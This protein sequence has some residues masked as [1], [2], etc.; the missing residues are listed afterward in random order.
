MSRKKKDIQKKPANS[1]RDSSSAKQE[2]RE[3][4]KDNLW[5]DK[6]FFEKFNLKSHTYLGE[7]LLQMKVVTAEQLAEAL[8]H[9]PSQH[10]R[11]GEY[12]ISKGLA[13]DE[14]IQAALARQAGIVFH[15][16]L[17]IKLSNE[18]IKRLSI[19]FIK[20]NLIVPVNEHDHTLEVAMYDPFLLQPLDD[21]RI[22]FSDYKIQTVISTKK[23]IEG[24]I[25]HYF[26]KSSTGAESML[27]GLDSADMQLLSTKVEETR[28]LMEQD[29]DSPIIQLVD[30]M[31][32][33]AVTERAS[34]IHIEPF[35]KELM[36]RY[37]ID[38]MLLEVL[39]PP[40]KIQSAIITRVKIMA[41]LN[42]A[43][44]RLPQDGRIQLKIGEKDLDIRISVLP[45]YWGER[46]VMRLLNK[47]DA[48]F[49]LEALGFEEKVLKR[50]RAQMQKT[51]GVILVTGPTGSGKSTTLYATLSELKSPE[52]N[53]MTI[54]DPVEYQIKGINQMHVRSQIDLTFARGLR[55]ILRQDPDI[56]MVG[57]I[58]DAETAKIAV[59]ASLTGH[60]VYSTLHTNDA[61][62]SL[63][64]IIDMGIEPYLVNSS[65]SG[66]MAQRL[67]RVICPHC[68]TTYKPDPLDL[69]KLELKASDLLH[70]KLFRGKGCEK[71]KNTGYL[72]R[73][74]INEFMEMNDE[75]KDLVSENASA[76]KI[77]EA[78]VKSGMR[79]MR[80]D[81]AIKVVNGYTTIEEVVRV[82]V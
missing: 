12:L 73:M 61:V 8:G 14:E 70:G 57:E 49:S 67:V 25:T 79:L 7:I 47:T 38:G 40:K 2:S 37:R 20:N 23:E 52:K 56:I 33:G 31:I 43:E 65:V 41:K 34:D 9:M 59:Q 42:I 30:A 45:C 18:L 82:S 28:D 16:K 24:A 46:V 80:E 1:E 21:I 76:A 77:R 32:S 4:A 75:I 26:E 63:T 60:L 54:E 15:K 69:K 48:V 10:L 5:L 53:I 72:G 81:A 29:S 19:R 36:V 17:S 68:K 58:R 11:L 51:T 44:T 50:Y 64:R 55:A 66:F 27:D 39:K 71:C 74:M 35:E 78:A 3:L 62:S 6:D 13:T 22:L